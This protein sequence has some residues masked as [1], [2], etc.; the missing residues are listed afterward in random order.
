MIQFKIDILLQ[1][2]FFLLQHCFDIKLQHYVHRTKWD[3]RRSRRSVVEH[4]A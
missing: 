2:I 3:N 1:E 4:V